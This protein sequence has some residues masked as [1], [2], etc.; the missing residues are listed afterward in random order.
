M[1]KTRKTDQQNLT[2]E[3]HIMSLSTALTLLT[4]IVD[5]GILGVEGRVPDKWTTVL[6]DLCTLY[7]NRYE[8]DGQISKWSNVQIFVGPP[9]LQSYIHKVIPAKPINPI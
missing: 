2:G 9:V 4:I 7:V 5:I 8:R 1:M 6:M 3:H